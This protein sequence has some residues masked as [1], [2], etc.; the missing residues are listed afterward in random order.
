M[1]TRF[2]CTKNTFKNA[3]KSKHMVSDCCDSLKKVLA[4]TPLFGVSIPGHGDLRKMRVAVPNA[5]FGKSGG[6]RAI[7]RAQ[8]IDDVVHIVFLAIYFK[9]DREDLEKSKYDELLKESKDILG[10]PLSYDWE[11]FLNV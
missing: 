10:D 11:D 7:Y 9:G 5:N 3:K 6:Y 4:K 1:D 2:H 8:I